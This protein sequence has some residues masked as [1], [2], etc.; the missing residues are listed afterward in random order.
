MKQ[1]SEVKVLNIAAGENPY[2]H[3]DFHGAL[4]YG[5]K[6]LDDK[7]GHDATKA[8]L[9]Q[10]GRECFAP[11]IAAMKERGLAAM[12]DHLRHVFTQEQGEFTLRHQGDTL[13]LEVTQ[14][15]AVLHMIGMGQFFTPRFC[16]TTVVVN[17][18]VCR[19]AGYQCRCEYAP[20]KG[21]CVQKF[22]KDKDAER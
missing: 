8:Y 1:P 7:Y 14:C 9:R 10:V 19:E 6:Y 13:V 3:K 5:I 20:G 2:L 21:R 22:W 15:P 12:E 11:L 16:E 17:E 4:C 18:T